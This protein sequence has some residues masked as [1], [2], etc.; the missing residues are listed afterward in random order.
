VGS[1][2]ALDGRWIIDCGHPPYHSEIHPPHTI[3]FFETSPPPSG[4]T[5]PNVAS[6]DQIV[7]RAQVWM[8]EFYTGGQFFVNVW[9]PPRPTPDSEL[10]TMFISFNGPGGGTVT[11]P[12]GSLT[13]SFTNDAVGDPATVSAQASTAEVSFT[14]DGL[15]VQV[16]GP[17]SNHEVKSTGQDVFP[18]DHPDTAS[19]AVGSLMGRWYVGWNQ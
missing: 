13:F 14:N 6:Q 17:G 16:T 12:D 3:M 7:T 1:L 4:M 15:F 5:V 19:G 9:P 8:N 18:L 10:N 2:V 11:N